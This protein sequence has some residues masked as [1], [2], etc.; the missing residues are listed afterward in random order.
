MA[1]DV[2]ICFDLFYRRSIQVRAVFAWRVSNGSTKGKTLFETLF[3]L[4]WWSIQIGICEVFPC[5]EAWF[6]DAKLYQCF[7]K[8]KKMPSHQSVNVFYFVRSITK[9]GTRTSNSYYQERG[10]SA[11]LKTINA[12]GS[13]LFKIRVILSWC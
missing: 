6:V 2:N 11:R 7:Y 4:L 10:V 5:T 3:S 13:E 1:H 9:T 8:F 12:L